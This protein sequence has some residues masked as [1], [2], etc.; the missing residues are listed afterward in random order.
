MEIKKVANLGE[1][2]VETLVT[3]GKILRELSDGL[4]NSVIDELSSDTINLLNALK[5]VL[6]SI[7][8]LS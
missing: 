2:E 6:N 4:S 3:T 8:V 1:S 7:T 5:D